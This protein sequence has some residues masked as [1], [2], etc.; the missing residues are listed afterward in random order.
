[1]SLFTGGS[2]DGATIAWFGAVAAGAHVMAASYRYFRDIHETD[3]DAAVAW[4]SA[5]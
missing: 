3:P 1:M 4:T 2:T 5:A